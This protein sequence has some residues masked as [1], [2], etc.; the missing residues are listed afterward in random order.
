MLR[1]KL[2]INAGLM[3]SAALRYIE[4]GVES[5]MTAGIDS[6]LILNLYITAA[7][8]PSHSYATYII[9]RIDL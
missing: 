3:H 8:A 6:N 4:G 9:D 5:A 2:L 1:L 7:C